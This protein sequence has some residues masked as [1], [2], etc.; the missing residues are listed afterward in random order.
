MIRIFLITLLFLP[1][2]ASAADGI[3]YM[4][5]ARGNYVIGESFEVEIRADTD[6]ETIVAAEADISF[7]PGSLLVEKI[8]TD[9]SIL[10][11]WPTPPTFS[12]TEGTIRFS[13][14]GGRYAGEDGL[15]VTITFAA[16]S[17]IPGNVRFESG[18][19]LASDA[20]ATNIITSMRSSLYS[21]SPQRTI[22]APNTQEP[23]EENIQPEVAGASIETPTL[24]DTE[25]ILFKGDRIVL[26]G[27][28]EPDSYV[29]VFLQFGD[30][31]PS[32]GTARA[33]KDGAFTYV[34]HDR[35][36]VGTYRAWVEAQSG[37]ERLRSNEARIRVTTGGM[38]ASVLAAAPIM[39]VALPYVLALIALG[40][41]IGYV[42]NRR[43]TAR[44]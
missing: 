16:V 13:G 31:V 24:N 7:P 22:S 25:Q 43:A 6:S 8:S 19:I 17:Q 11:Q 21:V 35:A 28:A 10:S 9:G 34:A 14:T 40:C 32:E 37:T 27:E 41:T 12:N 5:P 30:E 26:S 2:I 23:E 15:L 44:K 39:V 42:M 38:A 1:T 18:A 36:R 3:L 33:T 20:R 29:A 4:T